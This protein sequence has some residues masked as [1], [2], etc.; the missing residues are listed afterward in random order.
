MFKDIFKLYPEEPLF[1]GPLSSSKGIVSYNTK[2]E[3]EMSVFCKNLTLKYLDNSQI[4]RC[5]A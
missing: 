5:Y 2:I 4:F 1:T 3:E